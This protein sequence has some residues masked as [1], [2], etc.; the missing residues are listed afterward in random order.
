MKNFYVNVLTAGL[1][2]VK[3]NL[4]Q[5]Q[6][7]LYKMD[8][9]VDAVH[10][11]LKKDNK[12]INELYGDNPCKQECFFNTS[13]VEDVIVASLNQDENIER[14]YNLTIGTM[15]W[16]VLEASLANEALKII[17]LEKYVDGKGNVKLVAYSE[18][19]IDQQDVVNTEITLVKK[20]K[21]EA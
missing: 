18:E 2:Y 5:D 15:P 20:M 16:N 17:G 7:D 14:I 10:D 1:I 3:K 11:I 8:K 12:K 6:I 13:K 21:R 4:N 19:N 9:Y